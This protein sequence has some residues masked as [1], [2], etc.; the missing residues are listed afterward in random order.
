MITTT[1][2][3][4]GNDLRGDDA[5][6][7]RI[8]NTIQSWH[9]SNVKSYGVHQLTPELAA[10]LAQTNIVIFVDAGVNCQTEDVQVESLLPAM[11]KE[12]N[13]HILNPESL[14]YL[15]Q[16]LY[17]YCPEAWLITVPG[18]NFELCDRIS[19]TA[20]KGIT[21]ALSKIMQILDQDHNIF[22]Q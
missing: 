2:I 14:L 19:P 4:Y 8:A 17:N 22:M 7:Q 1:V 10:N 13:G 15:S 16:Y 18:E 12:I 20:Q 9:L 6:G 3:G 21:T 5:I 11:G